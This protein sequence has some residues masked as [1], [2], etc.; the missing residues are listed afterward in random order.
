MADLI[1]AE[2]AD[3]HRPRNLHWKRAAARRYGDAGTRTA[4]VI[5]RRSVSA[6][7]LREPERSTY[8]SRHRCGLRVQLARF[9][10]SAG[11]VR[12]GVRLRVQ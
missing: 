9:H 12:A 10:P 4:H 8:R 11:E 7:Q 3:V 2:T 5:G 1:V 6:G